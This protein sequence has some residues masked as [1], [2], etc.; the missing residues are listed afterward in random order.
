M[1]FQNNQIDRIK[2]GLFILAFTFC[3]MI[4]VFDL[5]DLLLEEVTIL[6]Q[7]PSPTWNT[8]SLHFQAIIQV[9]TSR[10]TDS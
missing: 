5:T 4:G 6:F 9:L 3:F 8:I 7:A 1:G 2:K 10:R